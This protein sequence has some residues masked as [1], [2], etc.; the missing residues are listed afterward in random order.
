MSVYHTFSFS[1]SYARYAGNLGMPF[2]V[3]LSHL[4]QKYSM[5]VIMIVKSI[6]FENWLKYSFGP[7]HS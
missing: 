5:Y 2:V 1:S 3:G 7:Y 4:I 6:K